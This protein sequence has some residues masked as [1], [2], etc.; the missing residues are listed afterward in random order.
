MTKHRCVLFYSPHVSP[1]CR[2]RGYKL[3]RKGIPLSRKG[4]RRVTEFTSWHLCVCCN[5]EN[6]IF[7][8]SKHLLRNPPDVTRLENIYER[9]A[10]HGPALKKISACWREVAFELKTWEGE[11]RDRTWSAHSHGIFWQLGGNSVSV[12]KLT[13]TADNPWM[14]W[15]RLVPFMAL[16]NR[17]LVLIITAVENI[18][19]SSFV[20]DGASR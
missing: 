13:V 6:S 14:R 17:S 11:K 16:I 7:R 15:R 4:D 19:P 20:I 5:L 10:C 1:T 9:I 12:M 8:L 18:T 3:K 2:L